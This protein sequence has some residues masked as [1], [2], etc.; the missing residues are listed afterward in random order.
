MIMYNDNEL[1]KFWKYLEFYPEEDEEGFDGVHY[2][3]I[4]GIKEDA[5]DEAKIAYLNYINHHKDV[6]I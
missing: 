5:P 6:K 2:G 4:K 1:L 3:G